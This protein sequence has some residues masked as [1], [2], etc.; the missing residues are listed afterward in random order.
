MALKE[1]QIRGVGL[2]LAS[3]G[4]LIAGN[5]LL[6]DINNPAN[7]FFAVIFII[8][9]MVLLFETRMTKKK[10]FYAL[11]III[12]V[13]VLVE[14]V[15]FLI[16]GRLWLPI[17][18]YNTDGVIRPITVFQSGGSNQLIVECGDKNYISNKAD[19]I[20]EGTVGKVWSGWVDMKTGI[21]TYTDLAI[22]NYDKGTPFAE[23][24][25]TIIT[26]GGCV[27]NKCQ[28]VEDQPIFHEG[29]KV[30][31]YLKE[32]NGEFSVFWYLSL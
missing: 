31:V 3:V 29:K 1:D 26:E 2:F 20:I 4:G 9:G 27:G 13:V 15:F 16:D 12:A 10:L 23:K 17:T 18:E 28:T 6:K 30:R 8:T 14:G 22:E 5:S 25:M 32:T 21:H 11:G 24:E 7:L 19:Y